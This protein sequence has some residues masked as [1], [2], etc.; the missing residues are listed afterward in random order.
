MKKA[1]MENQAPQQNAAPIVS[2]PQQQYYNNPIPMQT[3]DMGLLMTAPGQPYALATNAGPSLQPE[4]LIRSP[5]PQPPAYSSES[6]SLDVRSKSA[7]G[8]GSTMPALESNARYC[9]QCG[10]TY[11][12]GDRFCSRCG[13]KQAS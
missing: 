12:I 2:P 1:A 6:L 13:A 3:Q 10:F 11:Q 9:T 8:I 5:S 7:Q 4:Q